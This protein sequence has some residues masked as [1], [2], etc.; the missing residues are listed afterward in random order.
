MPARMIIDRPATTAPRRRRRAATARRGGGLSRWLLPVAGIVLFLA[1]IEVVRALSE[2]VRTGVPSMVDVLRELGS[3][4]TDATF[5]A[6][7]ADTLAAWGMG[8][9]L[10]LVTAVPLAILVGLSKRA[11]V[12]TSM[13]AEVLR[14]IPPVA[15]IPLAVLLLGSG[16]SLNALLAFIG[17][18]WPTYLQTTYGVRAVD[19]VMMRTARVYGLSRWERIVNVVL[20]SATPFVATGLR[21]SAAAALILSVTGGIVTG[22]PGLGARISQLQSG[23]AV[24]QMYA[25]VVATGLLGVLINRIFH[26]IEAPTMR[27]HPSRRQSAS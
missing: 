1:L 2:R 8:M 14:P 9:G 25:V 15:V 17:A 19:P 10:V 4:A 6:A 20:P 22:A 3:L 27:W 24:E 11:H 26:L 23:G 5:W 7:V 13:T 16:V 21:L 12:A 18:F